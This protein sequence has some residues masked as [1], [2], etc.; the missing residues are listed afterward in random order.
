MGN[1]PTRRRKRLH[2]HLAGFLIL[3]FLL[4]GCTAGLRPPWQEDR[5]SATRHLILGECLLAKGDYSGARKQAEYVLQ[6]FPGQADDRALHLMGMVLLHPANPQ[7]D[8]QTGAQA[9]HRLVSHYPESPLVA[10]AQ[11]WLAIANRLAESERSRVQLESENRSLQK[12]INAETDKRQ[13][14]EERL[15]QMKAVDLTVE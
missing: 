3:A 10:E 15:Q 11:T 13:Q 12:R 4:A 5:P 1:K 8:T 14:L 2:V 9:F 6:R 7:G